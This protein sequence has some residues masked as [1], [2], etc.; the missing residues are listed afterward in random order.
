MAGHLGAAR[1][2][3]QNVRVERVDQENNLLYLNGSVPGPNGGYLLV[4]KSGH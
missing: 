1:I 2:T 4:E 3:E